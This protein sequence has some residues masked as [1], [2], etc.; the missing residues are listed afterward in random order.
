MF[1][2]NHICD[3]EKHVPYT[4]EHCQDVVCAVRHAFDIHG[5]QLGFDKG[6]KA[7]E[8]T[9]SIVMV[10]TRDELVEL[11]KLGKV[12]TFCFRTGEHLANCVYIM[13]DGELF[14]DDNVNLAKFD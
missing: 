8:D 5:K 3:G 6:G 1:P 14:D 4:F 7:P 2:I 13:E 11:G 12:A 10:F 9:V